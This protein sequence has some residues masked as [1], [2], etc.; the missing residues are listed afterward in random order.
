MQ[1]RREVSEVG[2]GPQKAIGVSNELRVVQ[3]I[4]GL[5]SRGHG[6]YQNP[7]RQEEVKNVDWHDG[8]R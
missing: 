4:A 8:L 7:C 6:T 2:P 1:Y 3:R 5:V